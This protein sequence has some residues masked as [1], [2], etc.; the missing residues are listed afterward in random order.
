M[1]KIEIKYEKSASSFFFSIFLAK[2][3]CVPQEMYVS[4]PFLLLALTPLHATQEKG[5]ELNKTLIEGISKAHRRRGEWKEE[6]EV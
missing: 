1:A 6:R 4:V 5:E 2:W 3:E